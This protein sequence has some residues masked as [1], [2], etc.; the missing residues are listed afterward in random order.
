MTGRPRRVSAQ[1]APAPSSPAPMIT[2]S[3]R[4]AMQQ[5][6]R[7]RLC[8]S[9]D[10]SSRLR[11]R[12][13]PGPA[14]RPRRSGCASPA[15]APSPTTTPTCA[16]APSGS[17]TPPRRT[18]FPTVEIWHD[19]RACRRCTPSGRATT[20]TR[21]PSSS[22]ATTTSSRSTRWSCGS[23]DPFDPTVD[24]DVL[25]ARGASDDK[26]QLLFHLLGLRAHLAATGRTTPAVTLKFLIEGEEE[27]GSPNFEALL[28]EHRDRLDC[29]VVVITDTGMIAPDMPST[30]TGMRGMVARTVNFHGPDLDLHSGV[31]G[32]AVPNPATARRPARRRA[33][34]RRRPRAGARLLR[35]RARADRRGTRPVRQGAR[36]RRRV[37]DTSRKS[38]AL[39]GEAGYTH[40]RAGR[41]P[42]HRRG[43]RHRRW[44]PGRRATRRSSRATRSSS[45]RSG[46]WPTRIRRKIHDGVARVRRD[47]HPGR[48][49][50]RQ[51][52]G[53][54]TACAP[55][56][57]RSARPRTR[58]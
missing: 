29:D 52:S 42:A 10:L 14:R 33:A 3:A 47:A 13:P 27:S 37:P 19:G 8:S 7:R 21:R 24:G 44:L 32:G 57:C 35:R 56:S 2:T 50:P 17:P 55:A 4:S 18:G 11:L 30:V 5:G 12:P 1:A 31:F 38:R 9:G 58:R 39:H 54:A 49:S 25:R 28:A 23:T 15:S 53:R 26:G 34:R 51:W 36:R 20:P 16:A 46:W 22:T 48:A 41:R 45:C 6:Y 40:A 43:Q